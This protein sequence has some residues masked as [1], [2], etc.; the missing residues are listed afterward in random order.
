MSWRRTQGR[1]LWNSHPNFPFPS[2]KHFPLLCFNGLVHGSRWLPGL[3]CNPLLFLNNLIFLRRNIWLILLLLLLLRSIFGGPYWDPEKTTNDS[4]ADNK[5]ALHP[6]KSRL[7]ADS[8][9]SEEV[10][11]GYELLIAL[12]FAAFQAVFGIDL[13][14]AVFPSSGLLHLW[15]H[16]W[17]VGPGCRENALLSLQPDSFRI[18]LCLWGC[19][20]Q[21]AAWFLLEQASFGTGCSAS[22]WRLW[23]CTVALT[24]LSLCFKSLWDRR[25]LLEQCCLALPSHLWGQF[26][27]LERTVTLTFQIRLFLLQLAGI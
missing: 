21:C 12:Q 10:S 9:I 22:A 18:R 2:A 13:Q 6:L 1:S 25:V 23:E 8:D 5:Q 24:L 7:L 27:C 17:H 15:V 4:Q 20:T 16:L 14:T 3:V 19:V 26:A 11:P